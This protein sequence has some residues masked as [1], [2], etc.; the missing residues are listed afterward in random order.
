LGLDASNPPKNYPIQEVQ[1]GVSFVSPCIVGTSGA[2]P[3]SSRLW[4]RADSAPSS[5]VAPSLRHRWKRGSLEERG[6]EEKR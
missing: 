5:E 4:R 6:I 1:I 3:R 2:V